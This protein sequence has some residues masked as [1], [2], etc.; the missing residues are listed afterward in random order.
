MNKRYVE[1]EV[2]E[3]LFQQY[4]IPYTNIFDELK[5]VTA[6]DAAKTLSVLDLRDMLENN[7]AVFAVQAW[8][9]EDVCTA[10]CANNI[11]WPDEDLVNKIMEQAKG[12]LEDCSD[13]W[14]K[15]HA[16]IKACMPGRII[17]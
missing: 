6:R 16:V 7:S 17:E 11:H 4:D 13:N 14:D 12:P 9:K 2:L 5:T 8:Q 3:D 15:L 1:M 10:L